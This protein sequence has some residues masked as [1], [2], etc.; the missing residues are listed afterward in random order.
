MAEAF[1]RGMPQQYRPP[2]LICF[3]KRSFGKKNIVN[4]PSVLMN[5]IVYCHI[6]QKASKK[7]KKEEELLL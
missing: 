3:Q 4:L 7:W 5:K 2:D 6:Y 1:G